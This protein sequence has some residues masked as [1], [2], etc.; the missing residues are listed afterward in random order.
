MIARGDQDYSK[1]EAI[2]NHPNAHDKPFPE[3]S[4]KEVVLDHGKQ[5]NT[6]NTG[7]E[8]AAIDLY[9][10]KHPSNSGDQYHRPRRP[11]RKWLMFGG[12]IAAL[13]IVFAAVLGGVLGSR[14][15]K[16]PPPTS[17]STTSPSSPSDASTT[18]QRQHNLAALSFAVNSVNNTRVYYQDNAGEIV[19]AANSAENSTWINTKL[20]FFAKN[21]SA[22]AA[23]VS[24]PGYALVSL[25]SLFGKARV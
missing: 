11:R 15:N 6:E 16:K 10:D 17:S 12:G 3:N 18:V 25:T 5:V 20:G 2:K 13:L 23:A 22:I 14:A 4:G 9:P 7:L 8:A 19:E 21:G 24:R 1:L